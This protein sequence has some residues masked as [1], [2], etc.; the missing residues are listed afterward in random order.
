MGEHHHEFPKTTVTQVVLA[1][2][3]GLFAP[4]LVIFLIV[5]MLFG[6]QA[7]HL[8]DADPAIQ[9]AVV[10]ERIKPVAQVEVADNSGPHVDKTG[11]QVVTAVCSACH[12]AGAL[13]S[14]KIGD[15][16]AWGPRIAQGY[17]TLI[18]HAIEGIRSMPARGGNPDLTDNEV[19]NAVAYMA[20]QAGASFK[21]PELGG[22]SHGGTAPAAAAAEAAPAA[23]PA[24]APVAA[25]P[26]PAPAA[27]AKAA[28]PAA[29]AAAPAEEA[30]PAVVAEAPKPAASGKS[31]EE[32]VK[33]VCAMCHAGGLMGAPKIGD[34]D[35]W[36]PRIAQGYDTL[37]QH[38]IHGIRM[39]PAKGGNPGLSDA[40]VARAVAYMANQGG[41]NFKA[42]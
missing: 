30:K 27:Q 26:A 40:E 17:E 25:A 21:S 9:Q 19:A 29:P 37:V 8:V 35:G 24:A 4:A 11:E 32:V 16:A 10:E 7:S 6:I 38:A 12:A 18:K 15:K 22:A 20:N 39:M 13:G 1:T 42:D 3:G 2:L 41:A 34:K 33:G 28:A 31:G 14:P 5:K 23:A 36:A